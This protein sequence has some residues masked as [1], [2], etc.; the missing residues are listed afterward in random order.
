MA[1]EDPTTD[2]S[3]VATRSTPLRRRAAPSARVVDPSADPGWASL[4]NARRS[5]VFHSPSWIRALRQTYGFEFVAHVLTDADGAPAA[6]FVF[7]A[8][9]DVLGGRS[10]SLPFSDFCDPLVD[11]AGQW[12]ALA[13]AELERGAPFTVKVLFDEIAE[14][15]PRLVERGRSHWHRAD[16][17]RDADELWSRLHPSARRAVRKSRSSGVSVRPAESLNDV[18]TFFDLHLR[19]RKLK[20]HLLAQPWAFFEALWDHFLRD[21]NGRL[22][23]A[24]HDGT[25]ISG[26]LFLRW[27]DTLYYKLNA[28]LG[29]ALSLRPNDAVLWEGLQHAYAEGLTWLDF[30]VSAS[31]QEGLIRYKRKYATEEREVRVLRTKADSDHRADALRRVLPQITDLFVRPDVPDDV[32]RRAGDLLYRYF[33]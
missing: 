28:S 30:G 26:V 24:E 2:V 12:K 5:D 11:D 13:D 7:A 10:V 3:T 4:V 6:G 29:E 25:T 15:D 18:R 20:Y 31:D 23:L 33:V 17:T 22:L 9:D 14:R 8:V 16:T 32:T 21:G 27:K 1:R 19:V